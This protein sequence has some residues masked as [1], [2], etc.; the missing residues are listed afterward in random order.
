MVE[1]NFAANVLE[2]GIEIFTSEE[3][4]NEIYIKLEKSKYSKYIY[5]VEEE[6]D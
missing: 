6:S 3:N 5:L 1:R 2:V 4:P